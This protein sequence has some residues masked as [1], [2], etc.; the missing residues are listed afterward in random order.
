[1][2]AVEMTDASNP[3]FV[4]EEEDA[5]QIRC[6]LPITVARRWRLPDRDW[7]VACVTVSEISMVEFSNKIIMEGC[8][9]ALA[10]RLC[11]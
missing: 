4:G 2:A 9:R 6:L 5:V 11:P 8:N 10:I 1:M 3:V 7:K